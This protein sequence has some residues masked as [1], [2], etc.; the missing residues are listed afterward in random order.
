MDDYFVNVKDKIASNKREKA[1]LI[2][3]N[4]YAFSVKTLTLKNAEINMGSFEK[5]VLF[6][7]N[8]QG[9]KNAFCLF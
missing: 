2:F 3:A 6:G 1:D 9:F 8:F 7:R 5:R 4:N